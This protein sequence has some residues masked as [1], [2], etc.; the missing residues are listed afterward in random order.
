MTQPPAP[1]ALNMRTSTA[2]ITGASSGIG[3]SLARQ[4]AAHGAHLILVARTEDRLHALAAEL[5]A[6]Y[7]VQVHVLPADLNRPGAAAELHAAVQARGLNVDILVNNA[8]LGGYGEFSTQP[9]DEIDRMIAVNISALTGL[10]R[11]FLPD[12]LARGR[13]RV[14][15]VASTAAFQPGPLMAVYYATK[16]YVLSFSE[17]VAEEVAGSGVSVTALCPGPVQTGFQ[18]VSRL[19]ESDLL[20]GPARLVILSAD[21][22]ARQG[23]RGLLVGQRVVVAGRLNRVQTLLPRLLPR[24]V[25]TRLIGRVQARRTR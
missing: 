6:R 3:E 14:L 13:G 24:A 1:P 5:G 11:A 9:S 10:T 16:A 20:N 23:V 19:G 7:R 22:V 18:A 12:M 2:L 15:N 25:V 17:A 8:G 4:L 21:E